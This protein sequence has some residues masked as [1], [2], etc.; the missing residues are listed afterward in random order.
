MGSSGMIEASI[1]SLQQR[2]GEDFRELFRSDYWLN[3]GLSAFE[4]RLKAHT[5]DAVRQ[6]LECVEAV[7]GPE[8]RAVLLLLGRYGLTD[9]TD[10]ARKLAMAQAAEDADATMAYRLAKTLVRERVLSD[11]VE[12]RRAMQEIF[13]VLDVTAGS[14]LS[15]PSPHSS[16]NGSPAASDQRA[17]KT[18]YAS[19][20]KSVGAN[21]ETD[22]NGS[23]G[24]SEA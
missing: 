9:E 23:N 13:G 17:P 6:W 11:P 22:R 4:A 12:R 3:L 1:S 21:G 10:L 16:E 15:S 14:D 2:R 8:N 24:H 20:C 7:H 19:I 5:R 18:R